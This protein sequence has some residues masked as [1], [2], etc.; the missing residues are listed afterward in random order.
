MIK[1]KNYLYLSCNKCG[2]VFSNDGENPECYPEEEKYNMLED[3]S[4]EGW[5]FEEDQETCYCPACV[6]SYGIPNNDSYNPNE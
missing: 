5:E 4:K 3:A 6:D 1:T 2:A